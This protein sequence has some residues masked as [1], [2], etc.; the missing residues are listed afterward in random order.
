MSNTIDASKYLGNT[1]EDLTVLRT[2]KI[3]VGGK[4]RLDLLLDSMS[5]A[6]VIQKITV[7]NI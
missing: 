4:E 3:K 2:Q 7:S 6:M 5:K 1:Y